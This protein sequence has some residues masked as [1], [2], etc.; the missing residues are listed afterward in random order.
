[1]FKGLQPYLEKRLFDLVQIP[2][3][4]FF[5]LRVYDVDA[6][7]SKYVNQL[8]GCIWQDWCFFYTK[9]N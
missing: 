4:I 2:S 6:L 7:G 3:V 1:M 8:F 5:A 9:T